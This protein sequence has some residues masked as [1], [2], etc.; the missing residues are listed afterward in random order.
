MRE[1]C[2]LLADAMFSAR[3]ID[4]ERVDLS[5]FHFHTSLNHRVLA[6]ALSRPDEVHSSV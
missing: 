4:G 5:L 1:Q 2:L 3:H 6:T